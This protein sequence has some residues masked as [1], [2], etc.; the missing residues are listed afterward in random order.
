MV[1]ILLSRLQYSCLR[2]ALRREL[3]RI[4]GDR[5][6]SLHSGAM[7]PNA[8]EDMTLKMSSCKGDVRCKDVAVMEMGQW[9]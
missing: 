2:L 9:K 6:R 7:H 4:S 5:A 3:E 1:I 8:S